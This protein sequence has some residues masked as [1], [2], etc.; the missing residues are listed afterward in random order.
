MK[1][2]YFL[3][4]I[5]K[6][7]KVHPVVAIIGPRQCGKTTLA[8]MFANEQ[9]DHP[10]ENYF[11]LEDLHDLQRLESPQTTLSNLEGLVVIDEVQRKPH[12]FQT[13]RVLCDKKKEKQK[14]LILG[15]ASQDLLKQSSET[16][17]GRI[18]Y[19]ELTPFNFEE[20]QDLA[21]LWKRGGFPR[22]F[23]A[24]DYS[25]SLIWRKSYIRTF[26]EQDIPNLGFKMQSEQLRRF[27]MMLTHYHGCFYNASEIGR[28][29]NIPVKKIRDY[30]DILTDTLMIRQLQPWYE[31]ISKRQVKTP[32]IYFRDSGLFHTLL[33]IESESS[34]L[35]HPKLGSSWEGFALEEVIRHLEVDPFDC[36]FWASHAHA[37]LD[38]LVFKGGKRL[39]FEFK[40]SDHIKVTKSMR[41]A[42]EDLKLDALVVI[43]P[44]SKSHEIEDSIHAAGLISFLGQ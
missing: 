17:T 30:A 7:F 10:P 24:E 23:L 1:R 2:P 15:S 35:T 21:T 43:Y 3:N 29:L 41:I 18:Q 39:G 14:F 4:K 37:E 27:W 38:L 13:L 12:L 8:R 33:G 19:I 44:G 11:D 31:N 26:I 9:G 40:Y 36:F 42:M 25:S 5:K 20:V 28:S 34:L 32:K 16:L 22:S 6:A